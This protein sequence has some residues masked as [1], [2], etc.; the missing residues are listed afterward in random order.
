M[1][2]SEGMILP[3][4]TNFDYN[5]LFF[6]A[7]KAKNQETIGRFLE[8]KSEYQFS[9]QVENHGETSISFK[10]NFE[11]PASVLGNEMLKVEIID[12]YFF[13]SKENGVY[14]QNF[15]G[16]IPVPVQFSASEE[17]EALSENTQAAGTMAQNVSFINFLISQLLGGSQQALWGLMNAMQMIIYSSMIN[18]QLPPDTQ[19]FFDT[20][21]EFA[22]MDIF[23]AEQFYQNNFDF[24]QTDPLNQKFEQMGFETK[25]FL[26]NSGSFMVFFVIIWSKYILKTLG[27]KLAVKY[28]KYKLMRK[29]GIMCHKPEYS[30]S[31]IRL[32]IQSYIDIMICICLNLVE[33]LS[34]DIERHFLSYSDALTSSCALIS[35]ATF[36]IFPIYA[37]RVLRK[38]QEV[39]EWPIC[40]AAYGAFYEDLRT[41]TWISSRYHIIFILRRL[42]IAI[43]LV[44]STFSAM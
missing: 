30:A 19:L 31:L 35:G 36:L 7:L 24:I 34:S 43:L 16:S 29:L 40:K 26:I 37:M 18:I 17:G 42:F 11:N 22:K 39:L 27:N 38:Y 3:S 6:I 4:I 15:K 20:C 33:F 5:K 25:T 2:F 14:L 10:I 12:H 13:Q 28:Y 1:Q 44:M 23:S 8:E 41:D 9:W 21:A 32:V